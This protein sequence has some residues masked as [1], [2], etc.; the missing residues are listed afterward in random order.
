MASSRLA[1]CLAL[2]NGLGLLSGVRA[3]SNRTLPE[4]AQIIDQKSFNVLEEVLPPSEANATT[5]F[6]WPGVT[7]ESLKA[8]PFH[9]YDEEFYDI[10]GT[11]PSLTLIATSEVDPIFHEAVTWYPPTE[12]VFFV[13]NAGSPDAGTGLNKSSIVQKISLTDAEALRNGTLR[14]EEVT[15]HVVPSNPQVINPNGGTNYNGNI[16]FAGEGQGDR[17]PSALYLMNPLEPYNTTLLVNNFFGRQFNSLNDVAVNPKNKDIYF[18]DTLYGYYQYFRPEPGM[19]NQ[20]Y[21]LNPTTGALTVVADDFVLP[22]GLTFSPEGDYAYV[23]DTGI[24]RALFGMNLTQPASIYRFDVKEDGTFENQKTFA[25]VHA[26]VPDGIHTDSKGNVYAGCN[27]GV[28]V[29]N[30]SGKLLGKIYTG[31]VAA[32][33]QFAGDG[34]MIIMGKTNLFYATLAASGAPLYF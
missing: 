23:T 9:V 19:R 22:N 28:H 3:Q 26:R 15:V 5:T 14:T 24:S 7:P 1:S 10:I 16:I 20:V 18:T 11:N 6:L 25:Y 30:P 29:W 27:D 4:A 21:R 31:I 33:F 8:K 17:I 12:E 34:R 2:L 13:Q 32:N